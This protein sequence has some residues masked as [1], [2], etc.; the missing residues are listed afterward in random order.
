[1]GKRNDPVYSEFYAR[2]FNGGRRQNAA[3]TSLAAHE[4]MYMRVFT[5]LVSNRFEWV[6][7]PDEIDVRFLELNLAQRAL[8]VF[9]YDD[10]IDKY[11]VA[12]GSGTGH[13][14]Y[15]DNPVSFTVIG[16]GPGAGLPRTLKALPSRGE[17]LERFEPECVPI[18]TNYLRCPDWDIITLYASKLAKLD[19]T[20][21]ITMDNMRK[22]KIV[23]VTE[24]S[25][26]SASN[27]LKQLAEGQDAIMG[28]SAL[29]D[30]AA[31]V[32]VLDLGMDPLTLPNLQVAKSKL[33]NECMGLLGINGANQEKKERLVAAEVGANDEQVQATKNIAL[34]ARQFA[35]K[36]INDLY[37]LSVEVDFK[38]PP[39]DPAEGVATDEGDE[40]T[41]TSGSQKEAA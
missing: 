36:Q 9:Y 19:R 14:N 32:Q 17:N 31:S 39:A 12:Q 40:S 29:T 8:T 6:G 20:I 26:L 22:T 7:L 35:A 25:R 23:A 3:V 27:M 5:E 38:Q 2:F 11:V 28:T 16:P 21:E 33:W 15:V 10:D 1:M 24:D 37:G 4:R 30:L 34:N 13:N 18:W 41:P